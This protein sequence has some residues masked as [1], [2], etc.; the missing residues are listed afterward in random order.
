MKLKEIQKLSIQ[1]FLE[2]AQKDE[3]GNLHHRK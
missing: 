3:C 1:K 2:E